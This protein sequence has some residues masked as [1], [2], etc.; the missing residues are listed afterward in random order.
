[1]QFKCAEC[2]EYTE[3]ILVD[4]QGKQGLEFCSWE[5]LV[6]Y[7]AKKVCQEKEATNG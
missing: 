2:G 3:K 1:M 7:A 5:C 6:K 4:E